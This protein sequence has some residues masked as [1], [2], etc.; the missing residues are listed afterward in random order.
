[1]TQ[2]IPVDA[3]DYYYSLGPTRSYQAVA[4]KYGVSKRAVTKRAS[5][6]RWQQRIVDLEQRAR[7]RSDERV[8]ETIEGMQSRHLKTLN[9]VFGRAIEALRNMPLE[10]AMDA[11]RTIEMVIR[12]ERL[13][14]GDPNA[15]SSIDI[16]KLI[17][18]EYQRLLVDEDDERGPAAPGS[19]R[20]HG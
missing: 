3:F 18:S 16:E 12:Q 8:I 7:Q 17:K 2:R 14:R 10:S 9:A 1:V 20:G 11:V 19:A 4:E 15:P 13:I 6:E 5:Q